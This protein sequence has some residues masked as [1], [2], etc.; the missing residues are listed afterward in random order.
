[1]V[2]VRAPTLPASASACVCIPKTWMCDGNQDCDQGEDEFDCDETAPCNGVRCP[3]QR[4]AGSRT[5]GAP[6]CIQSDWFC[7]GDDDCGD[8]SDEINCGTVP[9]FIIY[10]AYYLL[11]Q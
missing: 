4:T 11:P 8:N 2:E 5:V 3:R 7:D 9:S 1:M 6:R 10:F